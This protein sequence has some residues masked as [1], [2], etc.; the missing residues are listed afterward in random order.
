MNN[1]RD[2]MFR[3]VNVDMNMFATGDGQNGSKYMPNDRKQHN[4]HVCIGDG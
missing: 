1:V 2:D 3:K 4:L